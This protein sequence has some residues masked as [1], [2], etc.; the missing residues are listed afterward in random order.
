MKPHLF[1]VS[2]EIRSDWEKSLFTGKLV[3]SILIKSESSLEKF[4]EKK[5]CQ[6]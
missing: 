1:E 2:V 4:F 5:I 6:F 3:K